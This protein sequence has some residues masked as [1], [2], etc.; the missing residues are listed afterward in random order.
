MLSDHTG[1]SQLN[2]KL[3]TGG[4]A[5][6]GLLKQALQGEAGHRSWL[7]ATLGSHPC[8]ILR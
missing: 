4:G 2:H 3:M 1:L 5:R 7:G 8:P 6:G